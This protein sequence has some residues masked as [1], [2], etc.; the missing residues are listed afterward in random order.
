VVSF[1]FSLFA[2]GCFN[3][4]LRSLWLVIVLP[5]LLSCGG[6]DVHSESRSISKKPNIL[7]IFVDDLGVNDIASWGDG[8]AP[9]PVLD[10]L[11][12]QSVRF[13]R[14]YVDST[15][16]PSRASLM[17][18]LHPVNVGFQPI[19]LGLSS[20][21]VT[22][23]ESLKGLGYRT[24]HVGKWHLGE[25]LEYP[26][27]QPSFHGFD[28][29]FGFLNHF[30]LQGPASDGSI[31]QRQPTHVDPWLQENG[32]APKQHKGYLDDLLVDK[33]VDLIER[34]DDQPWFL[35]LWLYSPH[36]P[37]QP[38]ANFRKRFP[39]TPDGVYLAV[40]S[41][42][43]TNVGRLLAALDRRGISEDTIVVFASDNGGPNLAR[44]NNA[45]LVGVKS[46]YTEGGVRTP[47]LMRWPNKLQSVDI[48]KQTRIL[49]LYP[50]LVSLAGGVPP[51]GLGG[52]NL[53][54]LLEGKN[55]PATNKLFW[56]ADMKPGSITWAMADL[57]GNNFY[58]RSAAP[59]L[60]VNTLSPAIADS[61]ALKNSAP[62]PDDQVIA[63]L[64]Q[65]EAR[66]RR[67]QVQWHA[68]TERL[69]SYLSGRDFQRAPAFAG[70]TIGF[71]LEKLSPRHIDQAIL[72]QVGVWNVTLDG[73]NRLRVAFGT[74]EMVTEPVLLNQ[75]CNSL[76]FSADIREKRTFPFAGEA[77]ARFIA[78]LNGVA[79]LDSSAL[80]SRAKTAAPYANPTYIGANA[81]GSHPF[82]GALG[83]PVVFNR[84]LIPENTEG[85]NLHSVMK[86][87]CPSQPQETTPRPQ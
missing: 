2:C 80:L 30:I 49:D 11:S 53:M 70:Y 67:V 26:E 3:M 21:L 16:S 32:E 55:I 74:T 66:E 33:A 40:L 6:N 84:F 35:N 22:L 5:I 46:T 68:E 59:N 58:Q 73:M 38:S 76:V 24:L 20:D 75:E 65:W 36:T 63:M 17:T 42:L 43:D 48:K 4:F 87:L 18:G 54:P 72:D 37:Y 77:S 69:P 12:E 45:P 83:K 57:E 50:T 52:R 64:E 9:T 61:H 51:D 25:A 86:E 28:Y 19:G 23:P 79:I 85:F 78:Y 60:A 39:D 8:L 13:R 44:D 71:S 15:C 29:W 31:I 7:L 56:A 82:M 62:L 27:I 1:F 10:R 34:S 41:Q 14:H 81:D 47:L